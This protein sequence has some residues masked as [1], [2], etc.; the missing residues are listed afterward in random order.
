MKLIISSLNMEKSF[1]KTNSY[2]LVSEDRFFKKL[3]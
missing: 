3:V 2:R 1:S